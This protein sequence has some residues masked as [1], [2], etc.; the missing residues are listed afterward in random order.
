MQLRQ[1]SANP[2]PSPFSALLSHVTDHAVGQ[3]TERG[4][5]CRAVK[6]ENKPLLGCCAAAQPVSDCPLQ[7]GSSREKPLS[8]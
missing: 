5:G 1:D 6:T 7:V 3:G 8:I 4:L 2:I